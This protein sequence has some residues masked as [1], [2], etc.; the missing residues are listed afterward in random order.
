MPNN[1]KFNL[2]S[3]FFPP[4]SEK[5]LVSLYYLIFLSAVQYWESLLSVAFISMELFFSIIGGILAIGLVFYHAVSYSQA[6]KVEKQ[7]F[8]YSFYIILSIITI[9]SLLSPNSIM[10]SNRDGT[11]VNIMELI[12]LIYLLFKSFLRIIIMRFANNETSN[13]ITNQM[14]NEQ[15]NAKEVILIVLLGPVIYLLNQTNNSLTQ[16]LCLS[17]FYLNSIITIFNRVSNNY[18]PL[19]N[20]KA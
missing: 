16:V 3:F 18:I 7:F 14:N 20:I 15:L 4:F 19:K 2:V 6:L 17:Y 10:Y 9:H 13:Q 5:E 12:I 11:F 1:S 8:A